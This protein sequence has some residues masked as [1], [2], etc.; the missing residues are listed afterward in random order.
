MMDYRACECTATPVLEERRENFPVSNVLADANKML[1]D[2]CLILG[3]IE[4]IVNGRETRESEKPEIP[5]NLQMSAKM[6]C[7]L[8]LNCIEVAN[9]I[10]NGL[11]QN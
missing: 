10:Y 2:L 9:V 8:S 7:E 3:R 1:M 6:V 11:V 5:T 4:K